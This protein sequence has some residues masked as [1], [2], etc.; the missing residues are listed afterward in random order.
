LLVAPG[1]VAGLL[2]LTRRYRSA[3]RALKVVA[4]SGPLAPLDSEV[5]VA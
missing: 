1:D 5:A 2:R 3:M 4:R